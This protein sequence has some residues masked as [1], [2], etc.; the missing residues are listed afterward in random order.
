M[1]A[2]GGLREGGKFAND[3]RVNEWGRLLRSF[4]LDELPMFINFFKGQMKLVG[5]RPLSRHYFSLYTPEM[6]ELRV[7]VKP[8]LLPPFYY[9]QES[10]KTVEE[11]QASER[12]YIEA[13]LR[14][15]FRTDWKYFWG[16]VGNI[17][18]RRKRS[19]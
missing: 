6:Q 18:F 10:P 4:W 1:Y 3:Y 5:V 2:H 9:E 7:K 8:G 12:R 15:P 16:S 14:A 13:Y 19:H 11:V 17:L